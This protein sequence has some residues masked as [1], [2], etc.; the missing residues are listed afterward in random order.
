MCYICACK[1]ETP[2][3]P[4]GIIFKSWS[5]EGLQAT[6]SD[7][8]AW[9]DED[10]TG[11]DVKLLIHQNG[12]TLYESSV[13]PDMVIGEKYEIDI[14]PDI[15]FDSLT[16][17]RWELYDEYEPFFEFNTIRSGYVSL[18]HDYLPPDHITLDGNNPKVILQVEYIY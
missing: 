5:V 12:P 10:D 13:I 14:N 11:P 9:D 3:T 16:E 1:K 4:K 6:D 7:G 2:A 17:W 8:N 18:I 15:R